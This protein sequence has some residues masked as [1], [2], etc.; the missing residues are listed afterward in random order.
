VPLVARWKGHFEEGTRSA[1]PVSLVD[2]YP[3]FLDVAGT[4]MPELL[5]LDGHTLMPLLTGRPGDFEGG[6]VFG[7]FEGEGWNHPRAFVRSGRF[8]YIYNHTAEER[9]Y[10]LEADP[11]E[12]T[13]LAADPSHEAVLADMR[14]RMPDDW[15]PADIER[16]V[17]LAQERRK[18]ARCKNVCGDVGW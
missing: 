5:P 14:S 17:L 7:E 18:I 10:D 8:K 3:T 9:L 16:R 6:D 11:H 1:E 13:D 2:L 4:R 12:S 15:D